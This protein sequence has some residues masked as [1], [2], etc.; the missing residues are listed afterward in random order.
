MRGQ[1]DVMNGSNSVDA[2]MAELGPVLDPEVE[3][4]N[5]RTQWR[6]GPAEGLRE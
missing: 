6:A 3:F 2:V 1:A 4:V 5:P